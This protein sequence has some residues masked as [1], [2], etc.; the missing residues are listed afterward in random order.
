MKATGSNVN[1]PKMEEEVLDYW[2]KQKTFYKSNELRKGKKEFTFY[3]G[4]PFANGLPHYG[5]LLANTIKDTVPRYWNMRGFYV[6]RRFGWDT[7]G[8]PVEFEVEKTLNLKGR[9]DILDLGVGKFNELCRESVLHYAEEWQKTISRLG[10]WVDWDNQYRTMDVSFMESVWNVFKTLY[11]R[12]LVYQSHKVVPYSPRITA[13]LSNFEANQNYQD[14]QDPAITVKF[15]LVDEDAYFLAWT[16]TPWTLISNLALAIGPE[17]EY[18]KV[19]A[20]ENGEVYYLAKARLEAVFKRKKSEPEPYQILA[21]VSSKELAGKH[22]APP[23]RYFQ[24]HVNA[25]K[26]LVDDF[27]TTTDGTGIVHM[28]PAYGEDDFRVC[29]ANGIDFVDPLD[30]EARYKAIIPEYAGVFVKDADKDIIKALKDSHHLLRHETIVHSYPMCDRTNGPLI[31]RTIPSWFVAVE[32]LKDNL[33][34]N[35]ET[36]NWVPGHLKQG[37]MGNWLR[38]AR[39]WAISRNR[40]WG[41]PLPIYICNNDETHRLCIGSVK[42]LEDKTG[43]TITDLHIHK[44]DHLSFD[45]PDCKGTMK[46]VSEV[47]DCW[48]ES[49]SMPYAQLH[50]PFE[51]KE[52]FEESFPADFIAEGQDQ[53]RGWFYTLAVLSSALFKKPAFKNVVVNGMILA[54]DGKKMSKRWKNYTPPIELISEYGADSVRLYMLNS[55]VL[56]GEDLRFSN[57][58][59]KDT[60]RAVI[61]PLWN[62]YS[63]LSTYA[64]ADGWKPAESL[65]LGQAPTV[66]GELDCW[67]ISRLHTLMKDVHV[68]MEGYHLYNVVPRVIGFIEDLTNWYIRLSRRRFWAGEKTMSPDTADAYQT[69]YYVLVEFSKLFAPLAPFTAER[70]Y[71]GLTEGMSTATNKV[72]ESVH[73]SDMPMPVEK[74]IDAGLERRMDLVRNVTELGRSLRAKHQIKTRQVLAG[75][76]VIVRSEADLQHLNLS[77]DL[78]KSELNLKEVSFSTDEASHVNLSV[79]PNLK[80]LGKR[81]GKD[82]NG[83]KTELEALN[84]APQKVAQLINQLESGTKVEIMGHSFDLEDFL[85]DRGPKDDRL[86]ATAQGATVLLDTHLTEALIMEGLARE[87]VNRIQNF[88]KDSGLMVSDKITI[89]V[90]ASGDLQKVVETFKDYIAGETLGQS[91]KVVKSL[92]STF[93]SEFE[94]GEEKLTIGISKL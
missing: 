68:E 50:Y 64:E 61:L 87:F 35:N 74:L 89:E 48:F 34:E 80:L 3:D 23:F 53:T 70:I 49:G 4:P 88:R 16:T 52:R 54:S 86:I 90:Q 92:T 62:A 32:K 94:V 40:F 59:V 37:R 46:R 27:V 73:L 71:Q 82:L 69:L 75:M 57:D 60:T 33:V 36:I 55:A 31:Y 2:T 51:N 14:V 22:Y 26:V 6:E 85:V 10:R 28:A 38:N 58:G 84:Q 76:Q 93:Q 7:H 13:I 45:C 17:I 43:A 11:D 72:P 21:E 20:V 15:K 67:I 25:F 1:L 42:E 9:Q 18:V 8:V 56:R 41:T 65:T 47:F 12:G 78:L 77:Q 63:F 29:N 44:I 81:L 79:K 5:H 19:R 24:H 91:L 66:K 30:E 83:F 39:D